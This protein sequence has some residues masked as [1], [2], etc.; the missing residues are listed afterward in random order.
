[1][2]QRT[3]D[4]LASRAALVALA[5]AALG[6]LVWLLARSHSNEKQNQMAALSAIPSDAALAL[7]LN[8]PNDI[9]AKFGDAT[10][11]SALLREDTYSKGIVAA[12]QYLADTMSKKNRIAKEFFKHAWWISGHV[13]DNRIRYLFT[14][15]LPRDASAKDVAQMASLLDSKGYE[16]KTLPYDDHSIT[17][18]KSGGQERFHAAVV[19]RTLLISA[20]RVLVEKAVRNAKNSDGL[21]SV[22][23]FNTA[24]RAAGAY[25][26]MNL[27]IQNAQITKYLTSLFRSEHQKNAAWL[28]Q[29][30]DF[31]VLDAQFSANTIALNGFIFNYEVKNSYLN[32]FKSQRPLPI[33]IAQTLPRSTDGMYAFAVSNAQKLLSEYA[34]YH[35]RSQNEQ[36]EQKINALEQKIAYSPAALFT[37]LQPQEAALAHIPSAGRSVDEQWFIVIKSADIAAAKKSMDA[38]H[39]AVAKDS[40][41]G[42]AKYQHSVKLSNNALI[43]AYANPAGSLLETLLGQL[44]SCSD[45]YIWYYGDYM[46][47]GAS[48]AALGDFALAALSKNT[49]AQSMNL[50]SH[51][52]SESNVFV[53]LNPKRSDASYMDAFKPRA[54]EGLRQSALLSAAHGIGAQLRMAGASEIYC[55][56]FY[57]AQGN[58]VQ[59]HTLP[60]VFET[61][62]GAP[63]LRQPFVV[64]NHITQ[65]NNLLAQDTKN[66]LYLIDNQGMVLW[67]RAMDEP[68]VGMVSQIDLLKNNKLQ[69]VF[70]TRSHIYIV[71]RKGGDAAAPIALPAP[72]AAG[73]AVFDYDGNR[74]YRFFVP[75]GG[76]IFACDPS[77]KALD[78]FAVGVR[79]GGVSQPVMHVRSGGRDFL[80]V[81]DG[82]G[83][84]FL[85]RRGRERMPAAAVSPAA[86]SL[87]SCV[88]SPSG[89]AQSL[90]AT[91][92]GGDALTI[93]L[94]NGESQK[95]P[96]KS[97]LH[98][99]HFFSMSPQN[100]YMFV[101][102]KEFFVYDGAMKLRMAADLKRAPSERAQSFHCGGRQ[103]FGVYSQDEGRAYLWDER[104]NLLNGFPME[105][106]APAIA[107]QFVK[108]GSCQILV[109]D[110]NGYLTSY[111]LDL[112]K[113]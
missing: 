56:I 104:G 40:K 47:M 10:I 101:N 113:Q 44:F 85:D 26:D 102:G 82:G 57:A 21:G 70:S 110:P 33:T 48:L 72:A 25:A 95:L 107:V 28:P 94:D 13:L 91:T 2:V 66:T 32:I 5:I 87:T 50:G 53:F 52:S 65:Q 8:Q 24:A 61:K 100:D 78:G 1:M 89:A 54:L 73:V 106:A 7:R 71:D 19:R 17:T 92:S 12:M 81:T 30:A 15:E 39:A 69:M 90:A 37:A 41:N 67:Q 36:Y 4:F 18:F 20:S 88:Y 74:A 46:V 23:H 29:T 79:L 51:A 58:S 103:F 59:R 111:E 38:C 60:F 112:K 75:C 96:I 3:I 77:G 22:P 34:K 55:S 45:N 14:I 64:K 42:A 80:I 62:L 68:I 105:A 35:V 99:Q 43:T 83:I 31:L 76:R 98:A 97:R 27:Y 6:V 109:P 84:H 11:I 49:L 63:L 9:A 86:N 16:R 93:S 108:N